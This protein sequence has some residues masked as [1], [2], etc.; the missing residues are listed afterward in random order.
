MSWLRHFYFKLLYF[1]KPPWDTQ[2]SPPELMEF[3]AQY[4]PG[5]ALDLGCGTGTNLISLAKY[6]WQA[7][8]VDYVGRALQ[9][10]KKKAQMAGITI[11]FQFG[12]VTKLKNITGVFDLVLDIGCFHSLDADEKRAYIHNLERLTTPGSIYL[13]YGFFREAD[14]KGPGLRNSD[15]SGIEIIFDLINREEGIDRGQRPSVWVTYQRKST[16]KLNQGTSK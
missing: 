11:D 14:S 10:A 5:R 12:D 1:R 3:I 8:G 2:V 13:M 16:D 7:T 15:L 4:P 9:Q 6:G